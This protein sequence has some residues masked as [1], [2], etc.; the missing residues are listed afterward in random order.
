M[1]ADRLPPDVIGYTLAEA[2]AM[3]A[4]AQWAAVEVAETR[5]PRR[6]SLPPLR[7]VR[8]RCAAGGRVQL[9]VCGE[10]AEDRTG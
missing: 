9:I 8:Q 1:G 4:A 6:T 5:P 3:L 7:V 2:Q 10:R